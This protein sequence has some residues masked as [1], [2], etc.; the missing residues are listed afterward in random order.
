[1]FAIFFWF[2]CA[3]P[4]RHP[5]VIPPDIAPIPGTPPFTAVEIEDVMPAGTV[6]GM[7]TVAAGK[8]TEELRWEVMKTT[9]VGCTLRE[10][11]VVDGATISDT[12]TFT[13]WAELRDHADFRGQA[14]V[15]AEELVMQPPFGQR[16]AHTFAVT[17]ADGTVTTYAFLDDLPGPPIRILVTKDGETLSTTTQ[18]ERH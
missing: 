11:L 13:K 12:E 16:T 3:H 15:E 17:A 2:A 4:P 7:R 1:M 9:L 14:V 8:P 18:Y 10:V 5:L 6:I